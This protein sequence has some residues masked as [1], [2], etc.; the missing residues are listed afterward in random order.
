MKDLV[1]TILG[2]VIITLVVLAAFLYAEAPSAL[3]DFFFENKT[4]NKPAEDAEPNQS[5]EDNEAG[6]SPIK[7]QVAKPKL[8]GAF[9]G[10]SSSMFEEF[11]NFV[12]QEADIQ[13]VF[14]GWQENFPASYATDGKIFLVFWEQY[15]V[16]LDQIISGSTDNYIRQ[17][18]RQVWDFK[19][20][21]ILSPLH[22]MNG[23][24]CP[25]SGVSA[26]NTPKKVVL[27]FQHI[28]NVF[29]N[30]NPQNVKWA[31]AV[32]HESVPNTQENS[33]ENYYPGDKYVDYVGVD[34]FNF[35]E[36]WQTYDEIFSLALNKLKNY[37]KP[38]YIFSMASAEGPKKAEWIQ[39]A[40]NKIKKDPSLE[41]FVWFNINKEKN[42]LIN[43][44]PQSLQA[45]QQ[46]I[47]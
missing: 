47:K 5:P 12:G 31:W 7:N 41:G 1:R 8:W 15:G 32:N 6:E 46:G 14:V 34:G 43:S 25:W 27:A 44:D 22:E 24:W 35:G 30:E 4:Q 9:A 19:S 11:E 33:I 13:A 23:Q 42:W 36:P 17:F 45:F 40:L 39:D 37:N 28:Y 16:T 10:N 20:P 3:P 26:G 2:F 21:V 29:E 38:I 18:A